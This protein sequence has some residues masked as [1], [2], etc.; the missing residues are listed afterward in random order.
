LLGA[1]ASEDER[2]EEH[3]VTAWF[4]PFG[5]LLLLAASLILLRIARS[6]HAS[7]LADLAAAVERRGLKASGSLDLPP[8]AAWEGKA[9]RESTAVPVA[10]HHLT[11]SNMSGDSVNFPRDLVLGGV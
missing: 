9:K 4:L 11:V 1:L 3:T 5:C 7:A 8:A 10:H 6:R 2:C